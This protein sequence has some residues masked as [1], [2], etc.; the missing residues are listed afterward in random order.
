MQTVVDDSR[1]RSLNFM[2][3]E[4]E[5]TRVVPIFRIT[6]AWDP[7]PHLPPTVPLRYEHVPA[8]VYYPGGSAASDA[9]CC[10]EGCSYVAFFSGS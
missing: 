3:F 1:F 5:F 8:E 2:R 4:R 7:V 9:S 10:N 6:R